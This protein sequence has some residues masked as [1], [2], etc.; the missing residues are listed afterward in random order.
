[1]KR[2][3]KKINFD[4][5]ENFLIL[6]LYCYVESKLQEDKNLRERNIIKEGQKE[7]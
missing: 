2:L 6:F 3:G 5:F 7:I 1:M 4:L